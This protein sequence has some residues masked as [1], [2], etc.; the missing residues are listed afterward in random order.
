MAPV[1]ARVDYE[2]LPLDT[3]TNMV[4]G[5]WAVTLPDGESGYVEAR[6]AVSPVDY[7]AGVQETDGQWRMIFFLAGD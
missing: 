6:L 7:R 5:W 2:I 4:P 3:S 1:R